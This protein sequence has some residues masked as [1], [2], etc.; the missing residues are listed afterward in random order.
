MKKLQINIIRSNNNNNNNNNKET[1]NNCFGV[2]KKRKT[3]FQQKKIA[4]TSAAK[5]LQHTKPRKE[6]RLNE[7][8]KSCCIASF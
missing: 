1:R 2:K 7:T 8:N 6:V 5:Q 4:K 3:S